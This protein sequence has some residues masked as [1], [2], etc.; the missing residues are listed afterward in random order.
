MSPGLHT[1]YHIMRADIWERVRR[2]SFLIVL[3]ITVY[4]GYL[5]MPAADASYATLVRGSYRGL[6]NA[7]WIG[8][9]FGSVAVL[10]LPLFGFYLVKSAITRDYQTGV[11][12]I[13]AATRISRPMYMLGKWLSNL[14]VLASI[15]SILTVMALV[16]QLVR[17]EDLNI[18]PGALI[19]PIWLMG[20]PVLAIWSAFAVAFESIP[21]LRGGFGNVVAFFLWGAIMSSWAPSYATLATPS[22]DLLGISRSTASIQRQILAIDPSADITRG[23]MFYS[24]VP[25][26][27]GQSYQPASVF[28]WEGLDWTGSIVLERLMWLGVGVII[29]L[30]ASV[31]FDR[32]DPSRH[33]TRGNGRN[34]PARTAA[35]E[36]SLGPA[37]EGATT[38]NVGDI[39]LSSLA[40]LRPRWR[41]VRVLLAELRIMLKGQKPWWF[42]IALGLLA[43]M[44]ASPLDIV[45]AY[46]LPAASLW[47]VL[48]WSGMGTRERRHHTEALVFSVAHPLRLHLPA[49]WLA[50][51]VVAL[52]ATGG[53]AI[54]LALGGEWEHVLAWGVG[55]LFV[56]S[57]ALALGVWSGSG[58]LFEVVYII[59]WYVGSMNRMP[60]FDYMGT[61]NEAVS[62]GMPL[63]YSAITVLLVGLSLIGRRRQIYA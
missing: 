22:N 26:V 47:P 55:V 23:G 2:Y 43:A 24:K 50:G 31:P 9:L 53:A 42:A 28:I 45:K 3:G 17:A 58:K 8:N 4:A 6:Y 36:E 12:Q 18:Q 10:V 25:F 51:V 61:T 39:Q 13:I 48:I 11:G 30:A 62:I 19:A 15:L 32:F 34:G 38:K 37:P 16:M 41:F 63:Y 52:V 46:W 59:L 1:L 29:A 40:Q 27:E 49:I 33:R 21:L 14:A 54:R 7:A 44:L 5:L 20:L 57:L 35:V 56:P 60:L